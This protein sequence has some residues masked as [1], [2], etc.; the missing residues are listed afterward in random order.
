MTSDDCYDEA[1]KMLDLGG[2]KGDL[3]GLPGILPVYIKKNVA[4]V[5]ALVMGPEVI[6]CENPA[7]GLNEDEL[8]HLSGIIAGYHLSHP[9]SLL[10]VTARD[11]TEIGAIKPGR[12]IRIQDN[13]FRE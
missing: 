8:A 9:A 12:T 1:L 6:V 7:Q 3:W 13:R 5:K 10:I 2:F 11:E 4:V